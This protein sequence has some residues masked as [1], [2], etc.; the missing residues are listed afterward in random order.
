MNSKKFGKQI[1][2][3]SAYADT[4]TIVITKTNVLVKENHYGYFHIVYFHIVYRVIV[5]V[6]I[7]LKAR[8]TMAV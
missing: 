8:V 7:A 2:K 4:I 5:A 1:V 6:G 3:R